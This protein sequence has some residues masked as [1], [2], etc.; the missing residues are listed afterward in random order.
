MLNKCFHPLR[1]PPIDRYLFV[2]KKPA[3]GGTWIW[4]RSRIQTAAGGPAGWTKLTYY[5][6]CD[7]SLDS[8]PQPNNWL[9]SDPIEV[10]SGVKTVL[11][12]I[13]DKTNNCSSYSDKGG[14]YR[15]NYFHLYEHQSWQP[16][17]PDPLANNATYDKIAKTA[18]PALVIK[19]IQTFRV[20]VKRKYIALAFNDR[21][22]PANNSKPVEVNCVTAAFHKQ[23]TLSLDCQSDGVWNISSLNGSCI[24]PEGMEN[25]GGKCEESKILQQSPPVVQQS[26]PV[27]LELVC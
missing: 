11:V 16:T 3:S 10:H 26:L 20:D 4:D 25:A 14:K 27:Y 8:F 7:I 24:C 15:K 19:V 1:Q 5:S 23:G 18:A 2:E 9:R 17:S 12:T 6:T 21:V 22:A 13:E